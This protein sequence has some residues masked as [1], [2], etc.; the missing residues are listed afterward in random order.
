M[1][2]ISLSQRFGYT[3][4]VFLSAGCW[5]KVLFLFLHRQIVFSV[6]SVFCGLVWGD[7]PSLGT[8][9]TI[10]RLR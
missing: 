10:K 8:W 5:P 9:L 7:G 4:R 6:F 1:Q 2:N 3:L